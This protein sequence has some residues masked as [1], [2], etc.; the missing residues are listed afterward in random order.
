MDRRMGGLTAAL[1]VGPGGSRQGLAAAV[2]RAVQV[3]L[4]PLATVGYVHWV[5]RLVRYSRQ[6]GASATVLASQYARW[7]QHRLGTR[8]DEPCARL[9]QVL[10]NVPALGLALVTAPTLLAHRLTGYVPRIYRY[11]YEGDAV[12]AHHAAARTSFYDDV[13]QRRPAHIEQLVVLGAGLDTRA[14]RLPANTALRCFEVDTPKTQAFKLDMLRR[15]GVEAGAVTYVAANFRDED[16][17]EQLV[18]AGFDP[19]KATLFTW[20]SVC[21]YLDGGAVESTLRTIASLAPGSVVAFDYLA[22]ELVEDRSAVGRYVQ[23]ALRAMG[24]PWTFGV[25]TRSPGHPVP[26]PAPLLALLGA[27][28]L[29]LVQQQL[30][31]Q[32]LR[33][34][35]VAAGFVAAAPRTTGALE[36]SS[37]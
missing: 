27:C 24:E 12:M 13:V 35:R 20:E 25:Q 11:P 9:M 28:G 21:M 16:W 34:K 18:G 4:V 31:W 36:P 3:A 5:T 26:D 32:D 33:K 2:F 8:R 6:S 17:L 29:S 22:K 30:V 37:S 14:H 10:P 7:M 23:A 15:A 1:E 19:K